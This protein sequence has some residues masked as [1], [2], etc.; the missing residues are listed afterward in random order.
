MEREMQ[1]Q[2]A[3]M[4]R[5]WK[6]AHKL[7]ELDSYNMK[8]KGNKVV[9]TRQLSQQDISDESSIL[10]RETQAQEGISICSQERRKQ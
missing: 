5:Y 4:Q 6:L 3:G 7:K 10:A 8:L 1:H 2:Y 9:K